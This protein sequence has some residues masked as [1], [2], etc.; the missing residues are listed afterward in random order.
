[1]SKPPK[2]PRPPRQPDPLEPMR[3]T[4]PGLDNKTLL[5][6]LIVFL[7]VAAVFYAYDPD[8]FWGW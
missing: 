8:N 6:M 2:P 4:E 5:V 7:T 1:M 3:I